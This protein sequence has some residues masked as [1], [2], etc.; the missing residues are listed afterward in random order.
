MKSQA[1]DGRMRM[2]PMAEKILE[3]VAAYKHVTFAELDQKIEGFGG[4]S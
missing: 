1:K 4:T 3:L 2:S